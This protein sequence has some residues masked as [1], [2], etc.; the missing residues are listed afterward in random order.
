[1]Q[2][3]LGYVNT[4]ADVAKLLT[5]WAI[6]SANDTV[7][8]LG[9]GEGVFVF[10]SYHRL[11]ELGASSIQSASQIYGTEIDATRY[12]TLQHAS[13]TDGIYFP[14]LEHKDFFQATFPQVDAVVGNPPY[15]RRRAIAPDWVKK[16]RADV[17]KTNSEIEE[18]YLSQLTD[19]YVYFLLKA[20]AYLKPSGRLAVI[21]ADSW[22]NVRYGRVLR[23]Y[24]QNHFQIERIINF[25]RS[26][27]P[28]VQVKPVLLFATKHPNLNNQIALTRVMNGLAVNELSVLFAKQ[29]PNLPDVCT[30][31]LPSTA[32]DAKQPWGVHL[33]ISEIDDVLNNHEQLVP[34]HTFA[35]IR[36]GLQTLAKDFFALTNSQ[37]QELGIE[38]EFLQPF[39]HSVSQFETN[40]IDQ[41]TQSDLHLFYCAKPKKELK[42]TNALAH[43][44]M[45]EN[46][47]VVI[48]GRGELVKG[49][50]QKP[51]IQK[52][53]RPEWYDVK[54]GVE[55][56]GRATILIPRLIYYQ[57]RV[58]WN[59]AKFVPGGAMIEA[60]PKSSDCTKLLLA[61]LNST[62]AEVLIRG[63]AQL[64]GGGT[65]T[66]GINQLKKM[67]IPNLTQLSDE[68]KRSL[69][70]SYDTFVENGV[71]DE[72]N[73]L[74]YE[75]L[76]LDHDLFESALENLRLLS[77][78]AKQ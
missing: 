56:R 33:K 44:Q 74:I 38:S 20:A 28:D 18:K 60:L 15:V 14:H 41:Q 63:Y 3:S 5:Q 50:H 62:Y 66:V 72:I 54:S 12:K 23:Q 75:I 13:I 43:I 47:E 64:Y 31:H 48:R 49:Y 2:P 68:Q 59:Q 26:I 40:V 70:S 58:L 29:E 27:F 51:R 69:I 39:A 61:I 9:L 77:T 32:L 21:V 10:S 42:D 30:T 65:Y 78:S 55:K 4:P 8:D 52:A 34:L 37:I 57:F 36:I 53:N 76:D 25:D 11:Q 46:T 7:L 17:L 73:D 45:G 19:L 24:L 6:Q 1:M 71:R 22:L 67:P 35:T 16:I